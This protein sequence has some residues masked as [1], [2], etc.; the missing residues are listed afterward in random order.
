MQKILLKRDIS[1]AYNL[2][3]F[4]Y[5]NFVNSDR[6]KYFTKMPYPIFYNYLVKNDF[7]AN[8]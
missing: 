4:P 1:S 7:Y 2:R 5:S 6:R 3:R 8:E